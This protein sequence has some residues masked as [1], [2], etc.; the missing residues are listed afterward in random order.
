M[1]MTSVAHWPGPR[2]TR[3]FVC[4]AQEIWVDSWPDKVAELLEVGSRWW[5]RR[6]WRTYV[7]RTDPAK[8]DTGGGE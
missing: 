6:E 3:S 4:R 2:R 5:S 7:V 8:R 1:G